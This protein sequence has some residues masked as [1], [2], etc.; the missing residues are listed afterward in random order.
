[1]RH[2]RKMVLDQ[3]RY[4]EADRDL[5]TNLGLERKAIHPYGGCTPEATTS[6]L[7]LLTFLT[8][9]TQSP[10]PSSYNPW[11]L[12]SCHSPGFPGEESEA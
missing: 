7:A 12:S 5:A 10:G 9:T 2:Q 8:F 1:M 3:K 4:G 11:S 6:P